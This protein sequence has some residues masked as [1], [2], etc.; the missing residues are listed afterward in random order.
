M[1]AEQTAMILEAIGEMNT[2]RI[3]HAVQKKL[4][5]TG[6]SSLDVDADLYLLEETIIEIIYSGREC[7]GYMNIVLPN[8]ESLGDI[9]MD[10]YSEEQIRS[11]IRRM[12]TAIF[13]KNCTK[14]EKLEAVRAHIKK[15]QF[16]LSKTVL[17]RGYRQ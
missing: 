11:D 6:S 2:A 9:M 1:S 8:G 3:L 12:A 15:K 17:V 4:E 14:R 10:I 13:K 7:A 16:E 5:E